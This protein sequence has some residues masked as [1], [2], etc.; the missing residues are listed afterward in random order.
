MMRIMILFCFFKILSSSSPQILF[1]LYI[2]FSNIKK[3]INVLLTM[4]LFTSSSLSYYEWKEKTKEYYLNKKLKIEDRRSISFSFVCL[5]VWFDGSNDDDDISL[6]CVCVHFIRECPK[7]MYFVCCFVY[8]VFIIGYPERKTRFFFSIFFF[9]IFVPRTHTSHH[10]THTAEYRNFC[11]VCLVG[12]CNFFFFLVINSQNKH[13][14]LTKTDHRLTD[15]W[16]SNIPRSF[17]VSLDLL[18]WW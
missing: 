7:K 2:E 10:I 14:N 8:N 1:G 18:W 13:P 17:L 4:Y 3:N 11:L 5:F 12:W 16:S 6:I 15:W 9:W